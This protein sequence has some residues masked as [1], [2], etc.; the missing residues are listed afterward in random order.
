MERRHHHVLQR[1][2]VR[3]KVVLLED[4]PDVA[5]QRQLVEVR[6]AHFDAGDADR[7]RCHRHQRVDAADERRLAG[8]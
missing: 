2:A 6:I 1:G 5:T 8:P 4:H 7:T 3:K